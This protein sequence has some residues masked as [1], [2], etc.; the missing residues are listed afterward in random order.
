MS[1]KGDIEKGKKCER[2]RDEH[3]KI[4]TAVVLKVKKVFLKIAEKHQTREI[5]FACM[6]VCS[7]V[8]VCEYGCVRECVCARIHSSVCVLV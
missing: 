3:T 7:R 8:E 1:P 5:V 2:K 6:C 4:F